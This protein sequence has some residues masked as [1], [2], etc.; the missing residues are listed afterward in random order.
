MVEL[1]A[2]S[3]VPTPGRGRLRFRDGNRRKGRLV[4]GM[5][6]SLTALAG[7]LAFAPGAVGARAATPSLDVTFFPNGTITV[8][9]PDGTPVGSTTGAP[10]VIPAGFYTVQMT[11]PGGCSSYPSST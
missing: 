4:L 10:T 6:A 3:A 1:G 9:L 11:G 7:M 5:L 8:T 2:P